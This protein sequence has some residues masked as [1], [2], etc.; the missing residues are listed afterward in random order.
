VVIVGELDQSDRVTTLKHFVNHMPTE[1]YTD[2]AWE[3]QATRLKG[4]T[5]DV[6]R[7][8]VDQ[9][10]RDKLTR[11]VREEPTRAEALIRWLNLGDKFNIADFDSEKRRLF[12]DVLRT[13]HVTIKPADIDRSIEMNLSNVAIHSEIEKAVETYENARNFLAAVR[14]NRA[15]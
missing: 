7:K 10:W 9:V 5:G 1:D 8:I 13:D 12:H 14:E 6:L 11:F 4:A 2:Q 3:A 15:A